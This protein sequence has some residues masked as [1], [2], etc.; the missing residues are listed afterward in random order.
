LASLCRLSSIPN[1]ESINPIV[2]NKTSDQENDEL[3]KL[4]V[5]TNYDAYFSSFSGLLVKMV[6]RKSGGA[7]PPN[8]IK[9]KI[10]F[11]RYGTTSEREKSG[12][13]LFLPDGK[14]TQLNSDFNQWIRVETGMTLF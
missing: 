8:E 2:F 10:S 6:S 7:E 13:Y 3:I 11:I 9:T 14:A 1:I 4:H 12:A 5:D